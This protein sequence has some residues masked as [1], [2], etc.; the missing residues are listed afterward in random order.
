MSR[1]CPGHLFDTPGTLSGHFLDS[2]ARGT[3][4]PRDTP[5]DTPSDTRRFRGHSQPCPSFPCFFGKRQGKPPK[6]N[7]DIFI[8]TKPQKS[9]EKKGKTLKKTQGIPRRG[10]KQGIP[11][12]Q[13]K[14]GQRNTAR[15]TSGP[16]GPKDSCGWPR[17]S[18]LKNC[19]WAHPRTAL[20][21]F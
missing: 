16:K 1:E 4:G 18:Q 8:P 7:K 9:L 15:D 21:I 2:P 19:N 6:K 20:R 5:W 12:K 17:G 14:E 11:K 3:K 13:G 10:K